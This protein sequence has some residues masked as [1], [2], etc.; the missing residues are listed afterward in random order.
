MQFYLDITQLLGAF[1]IKSNSTKS[2]ASISLNC[3]CKIGQF[4]TGSVLERTLRNLRFFLASL[5]ALSNEC[6]QNNSM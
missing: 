1:Q 5:V 3:S 6:L 2:T 4:Y